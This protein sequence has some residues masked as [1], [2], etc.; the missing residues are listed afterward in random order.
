MFKM[1]SAWLIAAAATMAAC[2]GCGGGGDDAARRKS[3]A[4]SSYEQLRETRRVMDSPQDRVAITKRFLDEYP[5]SA[6]TAGAIDAVYYYQGEE[7]GDAAGAIEY[8]ESIR[9]K[10]SSPRIAMSVDK[11]LV[12]Y[13]GEAGMFR[14]MVDLVNRLA[15]TG[16]LDFHDYWNVIEGA[17]KAG[18]W[19]LAR[20]FCNEARAM[21]TAKAVRAEYPDRE[22]S[23]R[24][25]DEAVRDRRGM[26]LVK[27]GWARANL[28]ELEEALAD[29]ARA[30]AMV[31]RYYFGV[32]E[33]DL[34]VYWG[35]TL[36]MKGEFAAAVDRFATQGLVL[37]N[38]RSLEGL[39]AAYAGLHGD[40]TGYDEFAATLHREVSK[41]FPR[42]EMPGYNGE[43]WSFS[44]L[45]GD[46]TLVTLWFPT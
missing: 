6:H 42:F 33:Y 1:C 8:A 11:L 19:T 29:F 38:E 28:G 5:E 43:R 32:P 30:D 45:R 35:Y 36:N 13:Y 12:R 21:A 20:D 4:D 39:K 18:E 27:D 25:V 34:Y 17:I 24:E 41:P 14:K 15:P 9:E 37:R 26:V 22:L 31:P 46:I 44:A 2:G 3:D 10:L 7:I 16:S 40:E 23:L